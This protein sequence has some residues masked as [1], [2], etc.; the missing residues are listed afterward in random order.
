MWFAR[1]RGYRY[2]KQIRWKGINA[3]YVALLEMP[4]ARG[5]A[6]VHVA[7]LGAIHVDESVQA[8]RVRHQNCSVR[9]RT[10]LVPQPA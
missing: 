8:Q 7:V 3:S 9:L 1:C 6:N 5:G 4:A 2:Y 10:V